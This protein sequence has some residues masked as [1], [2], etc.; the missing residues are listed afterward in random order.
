MIYELE[1][2]REMR[3]QLLAVPKT[4]RSWSEGEHSV[5]PNSRSVLQDR[6]VL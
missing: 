2:W 4:D 5:G 3:P 1:A 6:I